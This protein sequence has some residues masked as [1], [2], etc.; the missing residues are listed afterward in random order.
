MAGTKEGGMKAANANLKKDP[1][2]YARIG[3]KG[4]KAKNPNKG[5]GANRTLASLAGAK[6]GRVSR[7]VKKN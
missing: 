7:Y 2:F 1:Q 4:G 6:G 5:F 3:G